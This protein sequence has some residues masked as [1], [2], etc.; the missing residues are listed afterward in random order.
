MMGYASNYYVGAWDQKNDCENIMLDDDIV[1]EAA[2]TQNK[3]IRDGVIDPESLMHT[4]QMFTEKVDGGQYAICSVGYAG[5]LNTVN[6][7]LEK[8]GKS[9]RYRPL[10]VNI[11]NKPEYAAG[12]TKSGWKYAI[13]FTKELSEDQMIQALNWMNI[14]ELKKM[15]FTLKMRT[16]PEHIQMKDLQSAISTAT[17]LLSIGRIQRES[18]EIPVLSEFGILL[19][20]QTQDG[21]REYTISALR[22]LQIKQ[23]RDLK[24]IP[25]IL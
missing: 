13:A 9:Y 6:A 7:Q 16:E 5:G 15:D 17:D 25:S 1:K 20:R 2:K 11:P 24:R 19:Q 14:G 4:S 21:N 12:K 23:R 18:A 3:M 8:T 10:Y 22:C